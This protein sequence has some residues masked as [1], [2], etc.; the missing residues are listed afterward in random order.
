MKHFI[1]PTS[2]CYIFMCIKINN[3]VIYISNDIFILSVI[4]V[5]G[6]CKAFC[7]LEVNLIYFNGE[8]L[9]LLRKD[10]NAA[11]YLK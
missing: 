10:N 9:T 4:D 2:L 11:I 5:L 3:A 8:I 7:L 6:N 1:F